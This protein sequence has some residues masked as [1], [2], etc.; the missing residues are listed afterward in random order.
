MTIDRMENKVILQIKS[1]P[2]NLKDLRAKFA[3]ML[4]LAGFPKDKREQIIL[5]IDE[6]CTNV[7]K[8]AYKNDYTKDI[9]I[10][11]TDAKDRISVL[12]K[13]WGEKADL[14]KIK[15]RPLDQIRPGGL[16]VHFIEQIMDKVEFDTTPPI[17]T[18]LLLVK[19][20]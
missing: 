6:A 1:D 15:S 16:G 18:H 20:K 13:D 2:K 19:Y 3:V 4:D 11:Y 5:A 10:E 17:G 7:I 14:A 12:I 8:H 9:E